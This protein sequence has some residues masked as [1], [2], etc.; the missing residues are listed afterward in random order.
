[1]KYRREIDGLRALAVVPVIIFH[2]GLQ[3][4][5][6]GFLGV[7]VFFV[8]SGYLITKIVLL[9]LDEGKFSIVSFYERRARRILPA[10][11]VVMLICIPFAWFLF[12]PE[13]LVF[14]SKS[15]IA[16]S[17]FASNFL[18]WRETGYFALST[19]SNPLIN[20]WSLAV[21]EQFYVFFPIFL[22]LFWKLS[23]LF[24]LCGLVLVFFVSLGMAEWMSYVKPSLAFYLPFTRAWELLI[25][26][27]AAFFL[28]RAN[29]KKFPIEL[30]EISG[31]IGVL[32]IIFS[33]VYF[34]KNTPIPG[35]FSLVPTL[36]TLLV[37]VFATNKTTVGKFLG[38]RILVRIGLI[39]YS[40]YLFHQPLFAF[41]KYSEFFQFNIYISLLLCLVTFIFA[42]LS[43]IFVE[44]PF[45]DKCKISKQSFLKF[46]IISTSFMI[47]VGTYIVY[48][49]GYESR[50]QVYTEVKST[51][52]WPDENNITADCKNKFGG[53]Q[54]CL[55]TDPNEVPTDL[56]I[57]DSHANHFF[58]GLSQSLKK[59]N[60]NL[61]MFGAGG[62]P[63]LIDI[64]IGFH[65]VYGL[66]LNCNKRTNDKFKSLMLSDSVNNV[67]LSFSGI[68][69]LDTK[70]ELF[71]L[72]GE[73]D[74]RTDRAS[75]LTN[76]FLR[77]IKFAIDNG[78]RVYVIEDLPNVSFD[79]FQKCLVQNNDL[80]VSILCLHIL[81][82]PTEYFDMLNIFK[83]HGAIVIRTNNLLNSF[84]FTDS[85]K[86]LYRDGTHLSFDGSLFFG[87][88]LK[89][90]YLNH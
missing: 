68:D 61:L 22:I 81:K 83:T 87:N 21:E 75:A 5:S 48:K 19:Q 9:E 60:R 80:S 42:Y 14:F 26:S 12:L 50:F 55:I 77:T 35:L 72:K 54:Y 33:F 36:G 84:P 66:K 57:G 78:K 17:L 7:D 37:I 15:L 13:D 70:V 40:A 88:S 31:W 10:L 43:Y 79:N 3:I 51:L 46:S 4:F 29:R 27:F 73:I 34:N 64:D 8:I 23:K 25:G 62:C 38:N 74:F 30:C 52:K 16:V 45:R 32:F 63:P 69:Y 90:S 76:A 2:A 65:Y 59:Q 39:S 58:F 53:D 49:N 41:T 86:L 89:N 18:F 24:I 82:Q 6:G 47:I 67:F 28:I 20:T 71:D 44:T 11:F 1:M 85:G 56:L